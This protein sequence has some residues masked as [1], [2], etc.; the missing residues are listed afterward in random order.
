MVA[1]VLNPLMIRA[2]LS[3]IDLDGLLTYGLYVYGSD[4]LINAGYREAGFIIVAGWSSERIIQ[5]QIT[6]QGK[7]C[8]RF[9]NGTWTNWMSNG[10]DL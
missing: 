9:Y 2:Q 1:G 6:F 7:V 4:I 5:I 10:V 8:A 3:E